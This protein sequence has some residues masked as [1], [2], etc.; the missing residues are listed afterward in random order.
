MPVFSTNETDSH[1]VAEILLKVALKTITPYPFLQIPYKLYSDTFATN[2][3][4]YGLYS[5]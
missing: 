4:N 5:G 1:D 3:V 2:L